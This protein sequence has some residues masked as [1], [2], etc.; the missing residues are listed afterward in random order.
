MKYRSV[1]KFSN[2]SDKKM[3]LFLEMMCEEVILEPGQEVE[4][5]A[6]DREE[7]FPV[8]IVY[9][10]DALQIY[11]EHGTPKWLIRFKGKDIVPGYPTVI[12]EL[13]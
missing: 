1:G 9:H 8:T 6:E 5:L 7:F 10:N 12:M 3:T 2:D 4:L 13:D 11:P